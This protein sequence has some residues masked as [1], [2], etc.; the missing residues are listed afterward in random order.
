LEI[1]WHEMA[2][3]R[4]A[5]LVDLEGLIGNLTVALYVGNDEGG[6]GMK[7]IPCRLIVL[8][9][10]LTVISLPIQVSLAEEPPTPKSNRQGTEKP[11]I[12]EG[13][14]TIRWSDLAPE[15]G[16]PFSDPFAKL[17][18]NQLADLSY[19]ARVQ[20]LIAEEKI[21]A[22]GVDAKEAKGLANKLTSEGVDIGWLMAQ[23]RHVPKIRA[24]Q[25]ESLSK[26]I[27]ESLGD[28]K[29]TL[30]GYAIPIASRQEGLTE[31]FLL[32]TSAACSNEAA[33]S[34]LQAV[35]VSMELSIALPEKHI[36][37]R[38]TGR[39]KAQAT[40]K[41]ISN[42]IAMTTVQSAYSMLS[43]DTEVYAQS[44]R[45]RSTLKD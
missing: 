9:F 28:K 8:A 3:S 34:P 19:L 35:F 33:P 4:S 13:P 32:P 11:K 18:Q 15:N 14:M 6:L 25:V 5:L 39:V 31:F 2:R 43:P 20:R 29:V 21:K 26:S 30:T 7:N 37:L 44:S 10:V 16:K 40:A 17:T 45:I 42:G 22:D 1:L 36:P 41:T 38:V 27:V 24:L 12:D 23:R